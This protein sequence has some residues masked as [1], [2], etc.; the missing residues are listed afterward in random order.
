MPQSQLLYCFPCHVCA[1][2]IVIVMA[3]TSIAN[4][5]RIFILGWATHEN[6]YGQR[7]SEQWAEY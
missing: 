3:T 6:R 4:F 2:S 1:T 7:F 5:Y